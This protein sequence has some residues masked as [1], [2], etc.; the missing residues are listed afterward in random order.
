MTDR[1]FQIEHGDWDSLRSE[2]VVI[3]F[4]VF[5][6]EQQVPEEL[7]LDLHDPDCVHWLVRAADGDAIAT[8][9]L[10]PDGQIGRMAVMP[11]WRGR[12]IGSALLRAMVDYAREAGLPTPHLH[13]QE[14]ALGF[15]ERQGFIAE[16]P[17]FDDAGIPHR[18]MRLPD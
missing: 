5:V 4:G 2:A 6:L 12:G 13:A 7:E 8:A 9:R 11:D 14:Q 10:A 15:Y 1:D 16:G 3:R 17:G 18:A